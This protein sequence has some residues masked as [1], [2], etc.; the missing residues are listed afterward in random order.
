MA[1]QPPANPAIDDLFP[2]TGAGRRDSCLARFTVLRALDSDN[3]GKLS[4]SE[5]EDATAALKK[6]DKNNDGE[7]TRE[8]L[9]PPGGAGGLAGR[10][11]G[12]A[13]TG[14]HGRATSRDG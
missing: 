10:F 7:L 11:G 6:L 5:I 9:Q 13:G 2:V 8:E 12:G 14:G 1:T 4:K 3:D